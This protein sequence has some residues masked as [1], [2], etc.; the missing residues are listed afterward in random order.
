MDRECKSS[1]AQTLNLS[2]GIAESRLPWDSF[3]AKTLNR[4]QLFEVLLCNN[5]NNR[6]MVTLYFDGPI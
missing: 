4:V 2:S 3:L 5:N 1:L 6:I